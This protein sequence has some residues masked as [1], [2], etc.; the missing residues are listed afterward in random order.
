M[1]F[2]IS[3]FIPTS[4]TPAPG[5]HFEWSCGKCTE[6]KAPRNGAAESICFAKLPR[7]QQLPPQLCPALG[8]AAWG[9]PGGLLSTWGGHSTAPD[10]DGD[11]GALFWAGRSENSSAP[12]LTGCAPAWGAPASR[13]HPA[14]SPPRAHLPPEVPGRSSQRLT[15][16]PALIL[17]ASELCCQSLCPDRG[18]L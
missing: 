9:H 17:G 18:S 12:H 14:P 1:A 4:T 3:R 10:Q 16:T 11:T 13:Q 15:F 7:A 8:A 5:S 6:L 2:N